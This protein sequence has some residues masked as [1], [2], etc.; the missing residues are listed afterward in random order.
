VQEGERKAGFARTKTARSEKKKG[1]TMT[2]SKN[3]GY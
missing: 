2:I 1:K 3:G